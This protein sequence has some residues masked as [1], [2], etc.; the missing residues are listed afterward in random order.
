M[1][2]RLF[3]RL[4]RTGPS[5]LISLLSSLSDSQTTSWLSRVKQDLA[6]LRTFSHDLAN[7]PSPHSHLDKWEALALASPNGWKRRIRNALTA[8]A[9]HF[10]RTALAEAAAKHF[11]QATVPCGIP[12]PTDHD[13]HPH[14]R[15]RLKAHYPVELT[16][17]WCPRTFLKFKGLKQH[18][19]QEHWTLSHRVKPLIP[20]VSACPACGM[21]FG[22][23]ASLLQHLCF[24]GHLCYSPN[25]LLN[26][27]LL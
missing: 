13:A 20:N 3:G 4:L 23:R 7:Y 26:G 16:C 22:N 27:V 9:Q 15:A 21:Q 11:F 5:Y 6:W 19:A 10:A 8:G 24:D 18:V 14:E 17:P 1:R 2:L 12:L 25:S